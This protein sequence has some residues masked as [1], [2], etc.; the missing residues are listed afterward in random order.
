MDW[1]CIYSQE[2]GIIMQNSIIK[3]YRIPKTCHSYSLAC[4]LA[5]L[6]WE[7]YRYLSKRNN[8]Y[9]TAVVWFHWWF[10][11]W[12][13]IVSL[14]NSFG[15]FDVSPYKVIGA[16]LGCLRSVSKMAAEWHDLSYRDFGTMLLNPFPSGA[17]SHMF[18]AASHN[19]HIWLND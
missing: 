16:A 3:D 8:I 14:V 6:A 4:A 2:G 7:I 1:S 9:D 15:E 11:I 19:Q 13:L 12:N 18:R 10:Q 17:A 5:D